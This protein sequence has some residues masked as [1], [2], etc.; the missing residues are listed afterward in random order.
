MSYEETKPSRRARARGP[1]LLGQDEDRPVARQTLIW[2]RGKPVH[3]PGTSES[4]AALMSQVRGDSIRFPEERGGWIRSHF[5]VRFLLR[6]SAILAIAVRRRRRHAGPRRITGPCRRCSCSLILARR[7]GHGLRT[8]GDSASP[9]SFLAFSL[10]AVLL[11][12]GPAALIG[13]VRLPS[14]SVATGR[15]Q[16][17]LNNLINYTWSP[18]LGGLVLSSV[19]QLS[20]HR[21]RNGRPLPHACCHLSYRADANFLVSRRLPVLS[22]TGPRFV[23]KGRRRRCSRCWPQTWSP[24]C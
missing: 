12:G 15:A 17:S 14:C 20:T 2:R 4:G 9:A 16:C 7:R 19:P 1:F 5:A 21:R 22:G 6:S 23:G 3:R 18:L 8:A 10:A 11:G 13:A 24:R